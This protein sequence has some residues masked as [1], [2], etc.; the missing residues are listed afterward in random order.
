MIPA[1]VL[2]AVA[3]ALPPVI[4]DPRR[5]PSSWVVVHPGAPVP[6]AGAAGYLL[7]LPQPPGKPDQQW[8]EAA[9]A[10]STR[11]V[12]VVAV[13]GVAPPA[14]VLPYLDGYAPDLPPAAAEIADLAGRLAG[15]ALVVPVADP[16]GA[17]TALAAGAASALMAS[18]DP[19]W[20]RELAGLLPEPQPAR[21][22]GAELATALRSGDL[23]AVVGIP[24]GFAGGEV[25]LAG[26]S[27]GQTTVF[28]GALQRVPLQ[29]RGGEA[30]A[31]L[32]ALPRGGVLV[33]LRLA[34]PGSA[35][36]SVQVGGERL[37]SAA[38]VLARHQREAARQD[39]LAPRWTAE[40][41]LLVRVWVS[42]L[43]RSFEVVL[44]GPAFAERG[45]GT[46]WEI[47]RAW[48]D[49]VEWNPDRLPDLPLLEPSRPPVPPLAL[50]LEPS[51]S[52]RLIGI[53]ER[54]GRRCFA[55]AFSAAGP[56]GPVRHGTAFIDAATFGLVELE[57][58]AERLPGEVRATHSVT[59]YRALELGGEPVWLPAR[60]VAD[61]LVSAFGSTATVHRELDIGDVTLNPADFTT[62]RAA[63]WRGPHRMLR[64]APGGVVNLVPDG[65]G[66][67]VPEGAVRVAERFLIAGVAY[68]PGFSYPVPFGGLQIQDFNFRGRGE[69]LRALVA[70]VVNDGAWSVRRGGADL[71]VRAFIQLLPLSSSR[72]RGGEERK[73]EQVNVLRQSVGV[74]AATAVGRV[75]LLLDLGVN[76]W[77]FSRTSTTGD[78]FVLP[79]DTFEGVA[80]IEGQAAFGGVTATLTG[81]AGR[82]VDWRP[83]GLAGGEA[84]LSSWE[85]GRLLV[86]Y[87]KALFP[88][89]K[90]HLDGEAWAGRNLD[91]FS[92]PA[93]SRFGALR[94]R[95]IA[96][97]RVLPERLGVVRASLAV[98][99]SPAV[100][101]EAGVDAG[102]VRD[103]DHVYHARPISGVGVGLS[104][105]GPWGTLL[106][107]SVGFP[108][109]TPGPRRPT[110]EL[111]LL[112]PL[113]K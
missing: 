89:A 47:N 53:A 99:L 93:P 15:V 57:E 31:T 101:V 21:E 106:E 12:P 63:A 87:E 7:E 2:L 102:W 36:E 109:A 111:F 26:T 92:A 24:A 42:D 20:V 80:R 23:A 100:R 83:W 90:L 107:G 11:N 74:A 84:P 37:P 69:Q 66:G 72:F 32:P 86:V 30:V 58:S 51:Y 113:T 104:A 103:I 108:L 27:Y 41:R 25:M 98:P 82:R 56:T 59:T 70:G 4:P 77:D 52:Y 9:V 48:V 16:A 19:A 60:H 55:L 68:D 95:G 49:G 14:E 17:V 65:K 64:D 96:S 44:A 97:D 67:R 54:G 33:A 105:P 76:R 10:L 39:R 29:R 8:L 81:E 78:E 3:P 5:G 46:D 34:E 94:I 1:V 85:R 79:H 22:G 28:A 45:V 43:G 13:G 62:R 6:E 71:S 75:R 50:R 88:L 91:R 18:P 38:E 40:E 112:R 73:D 110:L 35:F 61:D